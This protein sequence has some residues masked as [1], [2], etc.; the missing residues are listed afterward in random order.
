MTK[1]RKKKAQYIF[2]PPDINDIHLPTQP[3]SDQIIGLVN[4]Y[5]S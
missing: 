2:S 4:A 5:S 1:N 3:D